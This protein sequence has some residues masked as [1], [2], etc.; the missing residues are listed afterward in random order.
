MF[1]YLKRY[2][3]VLVRCYDLDFFVTMTQAMPTGFYNFILS[4]SM[5]IACFLCFLCMKFLPF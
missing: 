5:L 3:K 1:T 4:V 2:I